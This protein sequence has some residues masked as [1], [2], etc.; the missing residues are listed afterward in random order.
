VS[1][2]EEVDLVAKHG[3]KARYRHDRRL[4]P[5]T[6]D[7][8]LAHEVAE[9]FLSARSTPS[10]PEVAAAYREL[11]R[12]SD[13][14]F[15]ALGCGRRG[16]RFAFTRCPE[17]YASDAEMITAVRAE[18]TLEVTTAAAEPDRPH[19]LLDCDAGGAYD[20]FR[21][22]HDIVGHVIPCAGFDR[23]GEFAAWRAQ[24]RLYRGLARW[25]L[26]TELHAEHS[27]RWT[28]GTMSEHK[29]T[30]LDPELVAR[31][32]RGRHEVGAELEAA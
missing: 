11:A 9:R 18:G 21:A 26:A 6:V 28:T 31:A 4:G 13:A 20:R 22:V 10:D 24:E 17:P 12:Q 25:A 1:V 5:L 30:L 7:Q 27:V 19:P 3:S 16:V 29:A 23:D 8:V 14:A 15:V 32:R 2:G